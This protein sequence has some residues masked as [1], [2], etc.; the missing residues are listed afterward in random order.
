[1]DI[2]QINQQMEEDFKKENRIEIFISKYLIRS[3]KHALVYTVIAICMA[4]LFFFLANNNIRIS[5]N[6]FV[7]IMSSIAAATG[8]LLA[9]SIAFY[10]FVSRYMTDWRDR[11]LER[12]RQERE[13]LKL[14][15]KNSANYH[16]EI[17]RRLV[18][19]Y[20]LATQ[21][22]PGQTI[23]KDEVYEAD[24]IFSLWAMEK[25]KRSKNKIDFGDLSKY[26]SFEKHL[27]DACYYSTA[28]RQSLIDLQVAEVSGRSIPTFPALVTTLAGI[29]I[30]SLVFAIIGS[31]GIINVNYY[32]S[33]LIIPSFLLVFSIIALILDFRAIMSTIRIYEIGYEKA[34][35]ELVKKQIQLRKFK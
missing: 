12:F 22:I 35:L 17:S 25:A 9:V 5:N 11:I 15:I 4:I 27:F 14:Q 29:L 34:F 8:A 10:T 28:V 3:F 24:H 32:I 30:F 16:P 2:K 26:D 31:T 21:Y 7:T 20:V 6:N 13:E 19:L 18:N 23:N 1:M 33:I